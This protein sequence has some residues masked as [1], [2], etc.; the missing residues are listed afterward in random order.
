MRVTTWRGAAE[1]LAGAGLIGA[2]AV[3]GGWLAARTGNVVPGPVLGM[4]AYLA[5]LATRRA[6]WS[7]RGADLLT[8]LI[9]AMIVPALVGLVEFVPDIAPVWPRVAAVLVIS[10]AVTALAAAALFRLAGG[11]G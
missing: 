11:R 2:L 3:G 8:G 10:T 7:L 4:G 1:G 6:D 5:L 9:G